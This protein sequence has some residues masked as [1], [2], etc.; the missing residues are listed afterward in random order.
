MDRKDAIELVQLTRLMELSPGASEII[1]AIIDGPVAADHPD[2][3]EARI[4]NL[5]ERPSPCRRNESFA[6]Q[7]GTFVIGMLGA[8]RGSAAP[9]ICPSCTFLVR[10][11]FTETSDSE[12]EIPSTVPEELATAVIEAVDAGAKVLNLSVGL[13][14]IS[15]K[16][17]RRLDEALDYVYVKGGIP[18]VAA[19]N[20]GTV[21]SSALARHPAVLPV[22]ACDQSGRPL[23]LT[24]LAASF[25]RRGLMAPGEHI[26]SLG[27]NG[28]P[29]TKNG[30]SAAVPF[31]TGAIALLWSIFPSA[32]S[33]EIRQSL[34]DAGGRSPRNI[35]PRRLN[36]WSAYQ[37]SRVRF[38]AVS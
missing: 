19:G 10:P 9:A 28:E 7:H 5:E 2:L 31:V 38:D 16:G 15:S 3:N 33:A 4:L 32:S 18:V 34:L 11:I 6:C 12:Q 22:V 1:V 27:S 30:T 37:S 13:T 24:N 21:G 35:V 8:R 36:A 20:Q 14:R 26:T 25:T 29:V 17:E 23:Q